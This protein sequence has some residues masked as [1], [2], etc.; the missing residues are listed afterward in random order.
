MDRKK[1]IINK[2]AFHGDAIKTF[3]IPLPAKKKD[4]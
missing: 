3:T 2:S 1:V 4:T